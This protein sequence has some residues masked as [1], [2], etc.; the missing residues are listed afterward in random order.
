MSVLSLVRRDLLDFAPYVP[1]APVF[2]A[3]RLHA[4]EAPWRHDWDDT[5]SGLNRYPDPA[6]ATVVARLA[7]IYGTTPDRVLLGRGSDDAIDALTRLA[8]A[9]GTDAV[10]ICPPTFGM[11]AA[12][13]RLQGADVVEVPLRAD[14]GFALD[15]TALIDRVAAVTQTV[16]IVY[17]CSPNNP[18]GN[19]TS[20]ATIGQVCDAL[21]GRAFVVVDEAY[22]EFAVGRSA[23]SL[24]TAYDNLVVLRTLSKAHALAG[25]RLGVAVAA[26]E[27]VRLLRGIL[28]PYPVPTPSLDAAQQCISADGVR[29]AR[30]EAAAT[31]ARR[32]ALRA[33]LAEIGRVRRIW[34]S[35]ANFLLVEFA[36]ADRVA[37]TLRAAG[38][39][40]RQFPQASELHRCIRITVGTGAENGSVL[41][42]L[43]G[44]G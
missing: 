14:R 20:L 29:R 24:A 18:T 22:A 26:P 33:D 31:V 5:P 10:A 17:L 42:I 37:A 25:A 12:A 27:I 40:V 41:R 16:K 8:C 15:A 11:Y 23:V 21:R 2:D 44:L 32:A 7:E 30:D 9:A 13:A 6:A 4:N 34:P 38:I 3:V 35:E 1:A 36:E 43:E 28:P 39:L 19:T